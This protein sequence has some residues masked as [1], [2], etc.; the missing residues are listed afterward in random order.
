MDVC[1][2]SILTDTGC[3][4][5]SKCKEEIARLKSQ[6]LDEM[7]EAEEKA[8]YRVMKYESG[9]GSIE[10]KKSIIN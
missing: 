8:L 4:E 3:M 7:S 6:S 10:R 9:E 1:I 5:C 2:G